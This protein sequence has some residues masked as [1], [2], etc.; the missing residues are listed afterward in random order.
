M[1][2]I[3]SLYAGSPKNPAGFCKYHHCYVTVAEMRKH[4]CLQK[5]C[6]NLIRMEQHPWWAER[7]RKKQLRKERKAA[8]NARLGG[9]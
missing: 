9:R 2:E 8:L 4:E 7:E 5:Q 6:K 3:K 1:S